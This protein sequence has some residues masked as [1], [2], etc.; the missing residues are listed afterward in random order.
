MPVASV[1]PYFAITVIHEVV[2][3][4][5]VPPLTQNLGNRV[6]CDADEIVVRDSRQ[7]A[8]TQNCGGAVATKFLVALDSERQLHREH[9]PLTW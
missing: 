6:G 8:M 9:A 4:L 7:G 5:R 2:F 1:P 3:L